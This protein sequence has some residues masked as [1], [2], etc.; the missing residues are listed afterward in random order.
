M[1]LKLW[2]QVVALHLLGGFA[3]LALLALLALRMRPPR[4]RVDTRLTRLA[5]LALAVVVL[6]V[7]LGGWLTSNYAALACPDFPTCHGEWVPEMDI[8]T[9]FDITQTVGPNYLGGL[10]SSDARVAIHFAHRL[11]AVAV[12]VV[13][14]LLAFRLGNR[15]LAWALGG[16]LAMQLALGIGNVVFVLPLAMAVLHNAGA[17]ALTL[18]LIGVWFAGSSHGRANLSHEER[19]L[20]A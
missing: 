12:L 13:V 11:G 1:T 3:T 18:A 10:L 17:A 4:W 16:V 19:L 6:Q 14:G 15:P 5:A 2:P 7:A 8:A 20:R 9:G